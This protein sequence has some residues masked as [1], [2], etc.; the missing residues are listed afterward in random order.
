MGVIHL[1][2]VYFIQEEDVIKA[3][4]AMIIE[5]SEDMKNEAEET[6]DK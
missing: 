3:Y 5:W 1:C 6:R 4:F 2:F